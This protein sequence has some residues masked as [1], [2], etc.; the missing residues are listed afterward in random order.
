VAVMDAMNRIMGVQETRP[1]WKVHLTA[2]L[3]TLSQAAI[4][5]IAFVATL[6]WPQIIQWLGLSHTAAA[7]A[8]MIQGFTVFVIILLSFSLS[9]YFG[10]DADQRWEWIT[11]GSL[12]GALV[13]LCVSL[14]FRLY[15]QNWANYS[16]TYGSLAGVVI[17]M[18]W[19]WICCIELLAAAEFN[20]VIEDASPLGKPYGQRHENGP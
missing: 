5:I 8:T 12:I 14:L 3:M 13:L 11:P 6:V 16:A 15:V 7:I 4:L 20:K 19:L 9:L 2:M 1:F 18:S 17:L 10:P